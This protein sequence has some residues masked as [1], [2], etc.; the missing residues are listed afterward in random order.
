VTLGLA[1]PFARVLRSATIVAA[2]AFG[3]AAAT[4]AVGLAASLSQAQATEGHGDVI[5]HPGMKQ[6]GPPPTGAPHVV[7]GPAGPPA[8]P[9]P[10]AVVKA[11]TAQA[12]TAGYSGFASTEV[13]A[14]GLT[15]AL[16]TLAFTGDNSAYGY[17][18]ISGRWFS[19]AGEVVV[20]KPFLTAT[21]TRV[22]DTVVLT[23][24]GKQITARIVGEAFNLENRGLQILTAAT[25]LA[26][27]EPDLRATDYNITLKSGTEPA[28]Y[29]KALN[30]ALRQAGGVAEIAENGPAEFVIVINTLTTLL[31]LMLVTVA[32]LGVLNM[33]VLETRERVHD[34]GVHKAL[35]MTPRQTITMVIASVVVT[36][37]IGGAV[38]AP[39]GVLLQR[40]I[41]GEMGRVTGFTLPGSV[42]DVYRPGELVLFG[43]GGLVIAVLGALLPAGWA[44]RTRTATAL[45]TE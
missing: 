4:F 20:A 26:A 15:G 18:M 34:L 29:V 42:V 45:R 40:M 8:P 17:R 31:T 1:Q 13:T 6:A 24:H 10:V 30:A 2:I 33:V 9:D 11:I 32:A 12:G 38:G 44:A 35:G 43:L 23:E 39:I 37:L 27:A 28:A 14:A 36:G 22:G 41:M 25:T 19:Q 16:E 5:V 7:T 21:H 3:A